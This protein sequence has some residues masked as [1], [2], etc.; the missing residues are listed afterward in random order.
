MQ[1]D[2]IQFFKK[3]FKI[4]EL[5]TCREYLSIMK[6]FEANS[7]WARI[8]YLLKARHETLTDLC[9]GCGITYSSVNNQR[10]RNNLPKVEQFYAMARYL[11]VSME[12]LLTGT[13]RDAELSES[14][15]EVTNILKKDEELFD[16]VCTLLKVKR[17]DSS[18]RGAK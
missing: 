7:F 8:G 1:D 10:T 5:T 17:G 14:M 18:S 4:V 6:E 2:F 11:G 13:E 16:A 3:F 15:R 9:K 12:Y